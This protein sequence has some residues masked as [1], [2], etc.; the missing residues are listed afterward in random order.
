MAIH[1]LEK[2]DKLGL[3]V[4]DDL[5]V[6]S[7]DQGD[8]FDFY[9][10]PLTYINQP[11]VELGKGAVQLLLDNINDKTKEVKEICLKAELV[12]RES[13]GTKDNAVI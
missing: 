13:C 6:I 8:A 9:Y 10:C 1:G 12:V 5:G 7:F 3:K 11:I 2:I 4:P